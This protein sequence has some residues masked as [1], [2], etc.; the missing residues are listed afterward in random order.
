VND[1]AKNFSIVDKGLT[2]DGTVSCKGK[3]IIKGTVKGKLEGDTVIIAE[4]GAAYADTAVRSMTI[5][6]KFEGQI[7]ASNELIILASGVCSG[8]VVCKN[9]VVEAGGILN[10][11][12]K[13]TN[14][15][16]IKPTAE[17]TAAIKPEVAQPAA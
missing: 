6:G 16:E 1:K 14:F 9:L 17:K 7:E 15:Q 8:K 11:E 4:E 13:C 10:A 3:L 2:V 12:V 5:G